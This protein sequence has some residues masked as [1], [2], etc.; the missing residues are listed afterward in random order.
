VVEATKNYTGEAWLK[1]IIVSM[2]LPY[3]FKW[4]KMRHSKWKVV[5][6]KMRI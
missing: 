4:N 2:V 5:R 1:R 6:I 3:C